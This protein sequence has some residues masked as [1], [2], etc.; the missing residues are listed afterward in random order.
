MAKSELEVQLTSTQLEDTARSDIS[1]YNNLLTFHEVQQIV[2]RA[3]GSEAEAH[4]F[5]LKPY[6]DGKLGF[7]GSHKRLSIET[8]TKNG[9]ETLTFFVKVVPYE[10]PAQAQYVIDKYVFLK[11]RI[12]HRDIVP[13][14]QHKYKSE[15][16]TPACYLT[17]ENL[18]VFE[19]LGANGYSMRNKLLTKELIVSGLTTIA[20][21]HAAS[22]LAEARLG[23][24]LKKLYP[25][26]FVENAFCQTGKTR[27]W[28]DT[29]V[30]A[31]IAVAKQLGLD[32]SL[33]PK[34]CEEVFAAMESSSTKR[35][36]ISH[37]DLWSNN[38]MFSD[39]VPPKCLLVD[40]QLFRYSPLAHDVAQFLYLCADRK[41]R[42][43]SEETML[44]HYYSVLCETLNLTKAISV[45]V[46]PWSE[47]VQ[48]MEEQR[49]G[50]LITAATYYQTVLLDENLG[51]QIM[52]DPESYSEY[53]FENRN[54]IVLQNIQNDPEYGRRLTDVVTELVEIS[55]RLD[56]L[57][58][59]T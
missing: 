44:K 1:I 27:E 52:N 50:A 42:E 34:A 43:T 46:P 32:A 6:S 29:G 12:F 49:L 7:L 38:L 39:S 16:W 55:F 36:V 35:N 48:G 14:L 56:E 17:K 53:V 51:A 13:Q 5:S 8:K 21:L 18:L 22:L 59:P 57:P 40:F 33:I 9:K 3:L 41:F 47:L 4:K 54:E 25:Y 26:T 30:K 15:P 37:G 2:K 10:V 45:E 23:T 28:F 58:K 20:R 31:I 24:S 11:E 19:D